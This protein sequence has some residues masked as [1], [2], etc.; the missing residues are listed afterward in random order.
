MDTLGQNETVRLPDSLERQFGALRRRLWQWETALTACRA[1]GALVVSYLVLLLSD[2]FWDT[3]AVT[4]TALNLVATGIALFCLAQWA[5]RWWF[6]PPDKRELAVRVQTRFRRLGDRLLGIVELAEEHQHTAAFSPDL[7]RAAIRQVSAEAE[8]YDFLAAIDLRKLKAFMAGGLG[9]LLLAAFPWALSPLLGRSTL[10]RWL[11]PFKSLPRFSL[12][13]LEGLPVEQVTALGEPFEIQVAVRYHSRWQPRTLR[14][15]IPGQQPLRATVDGNASHTVLR[16]PRQTQSGVL[17]L[18]LGD[19]FQDIRVTPV[20]RP[21][22]REIQAQVDL[23]DY[24]GL[25][26]RTEPAVAGTLTVVE[27]SRLRLQATASRPLRTATLTTAADSRQN[28]AVSNANFSTPSLPAEHNQTFNLDWQ[29][30]FGLSAAAPWRLTVQTSA[31][32]PP[33][34][35]F[36]DLPRD[37]VLLESEFLALRPSARDEF[38]VR[39]LGVVWRVAEASESTNAEPQ[40][41]FQ[42]KADQ[43]DATSL[44][45]EVRF[46][47]AVAGVPP[48]TTLEIRAVA[49]DFHPDRGPGLSPIHRIRVVGNERHAE[50]LRRRFENVM[51]RLE[52]ITRLE[53]QVAAH[54]RELTQQAEADLATPQATAKIDQTRGNQEL[55]KAA[56]E[57]LAREAGAVVREAARN[58]T[59][60]AD[61]LQGWV[62]N[63]SGM[64]DLAA[65]PMAQAS[66]SLRAAQQ[67]ADERAPQLEQALAKEQEVLAALEQLQRQV[68]R[69][70]DQLQAQT[71]AQRLRQLARSQNDIATRLLRVVPD[72]VGLLREDLN[73]TQ[74]RLYQHLVEDQGGALKESQTVEGEISRFFER[75]TRGPYGQV[76]REMKEQRVGESLDT[77]RAQIES[78]LAMLALDNLATWSG[79]FEGWAQLLESRLAEEGAG[80]GGEGGGNNP[81][82]QA[83]LQQLIQLVRLRNDEINLRAR[84]ETV[85]ARKAVDARYPEMSRQ[86]LEAQ[87]RTSGGLLESLFETRL[88]F[89]VP[90]LQEAYAAMHEAEDALAEPTTGPPAITAQTRAVEQLSD[91]IN[92]VNEQARRAEQESSS[93]SSAMRMVMQMLALPQNAAAASGQPPPPGGGNPGG[94]DAD[95]GASSPGGDAEGRAGPTRSSGKGSGRS[96]NLPSEFRDALDHYY[97]T[98][99]QNP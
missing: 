70:L 57:Q 63:L 16:V 88:P 51:A 54:T 95:P 74:R 31:D 4:R 83:I 73:P 35:E 29:D 27:G 22:L 17:A 58:P 28:L 38:G 72:T 40:V 66:E 69:S 53:D 12:V 81:A 86:L 13:T 67:S 85:D 1:L 79:R 15:R 56:L 6:K 24:L 18:R 11:L 48:D 75:T 49:H 84:T 44:S 64:T 68:N 99:E 97:Q 98:L 87:K 52:E 37:A 62:E 20:Q 19:A 91:A 50:I 55:A 47:P 46:N 25:S 61:L 77:T 3:P 41:L 8:K 82:A 59:L 76:S 90:P 80:A 21:S 42:R 93:A 23:P 39:D 33:A 45:S 2:R 36:T 96:G 60:S 7:Y 89:L 32:L 65:Q 5:R 34:V 92:L 94:G 26:P 10:E 71:L 30:T 14:A 9:L 78:N 43:Y